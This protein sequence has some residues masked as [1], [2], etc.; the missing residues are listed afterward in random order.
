[1]PTDT[2][3]KRKRLADLLWMARNIKREDITRERNLLT[4]KWFDYR[5]L[6]PLEATELF[7]EAYRAQYKI[8]FTREID[9]SHADAVD[10]VRL[11]QLYNDPKMRTQIWRARQRADETGMPYDVYMQASFNFAS[12]KSVVNDGGRTRA[13]ILDR[14]SVV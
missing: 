2:E 1:M 6:S 12:R 13:R 5:F 9:R 4:S 10:G 14:K 8:E 3:M 7:V 11:E